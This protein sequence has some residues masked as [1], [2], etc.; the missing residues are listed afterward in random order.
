MQRR[1]DLFDKNEIPR[2]ISSF[3]AVN[4]CQD[5]RMREK[6]KRVQRIHVFVCG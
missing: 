5:E 3:I 1:T 6:G 4:P 2:K